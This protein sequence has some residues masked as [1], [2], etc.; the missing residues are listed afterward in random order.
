MEQK[1]QQ[2]VSEFLQ[3]IKGSLSRCEWKKFQNPGA[4][5]SDLKWRIWESAQRNA[6]LETIVKK[7]KDS[8]SSRQRLD[9][10]NVTLDPDTAHPELI[11]SADQ[12][13]VRRGPHQALPKNPERF[14][15]EPSVLGCEGFTSGRHYWEVGVGGVCAVG[16]TRES[17]RRKGWISLYPEQGIWAVLCWKSQYR[18]HTSPEQIIPLSPS[19]G[20][21]RIRV[22]LDY[23][24]GRVMLD[25]CW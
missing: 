9:K 22:Y 14:D 19:R 24:V 11:V 23:E 5:S 13:N 7:F 20:P 8:L 3:D 18:A 2:P 21:R 12:R 17:V 15:I 1:C 16:V 6:S 10:A 4:F 25:R